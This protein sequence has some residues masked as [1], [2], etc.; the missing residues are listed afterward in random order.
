MV[1]YGSL[2]AVRSVVETTEAAGHCRSGRNGPA[3]GPLYVTP[4]PLHAV[5][6]SPVVPPC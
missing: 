6:V 3:D 2:G 5:H 1:L 4:V